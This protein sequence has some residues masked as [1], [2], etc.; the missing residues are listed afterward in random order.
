MTQRKLTFNHDKLSFLLLNIIG[1]D[2]IHDFGQPSCDK[3]RQVRK[4]IE[5]IRPLLLANSEEEET[6]DE[7]NNNKRKKR[8]EDENGTIDKKIKRGSITGAGIAR[9]ESKTVS[10]FHARNFGNFFQKVGNMK[11]LSDK[12]FV[13]RENNANVGSNFETPITSSIR[14]A[15]SIYSSLGTE[16]MDRNMVE[17]LESTKCNVMMILFHNFLNTKKIYGD[18]E[19]FVS[20]LSICETVFSNN[21]ELGLLPQHLHDYI[22]GLILLKVTENL[23]VTIVIDAR[24]NLWNTIQIR[25]VLLNNFGNENDKSNT[26]IINENIQLSNIIN[27]NFSTIIDDFFKSKF[28]FFDS[29]ADFMHGPIHTG[30][31]SI[32]SIPSIPSVRQIDDNKKSVERSRDL[33]DKKSVER[34]RDLPDKKTQQ[35]NPTLADSTKNPLRSG[36]KINNVSTVIINEND[37]KK[38]RK[39][40]SFKDGVFNDILTDSDI[41]G[42]IQSIRNA[43]YYYTMGSKGYLAENEQRDFSLDILKATFHKKSNPIP[44]SNDLLSVFIERQR[45]VVINLYCDMFQKLHV[46]TIKI[47]S[48]RTT[49]VYALA[50]QYKR[51]IKNIDDVIENSL[52]NIFKFDYQLRKK[53]DEKIRKDEIENNKN[54]LAASSGNLTN[55]NKETSYKFISFIAKSALY[56]TDCCDSSGNIIKKSGEGILNKEIE[57]IRA[58]AG[59]DGPHTG[60]YWKVGARALDIDTHLFSYIKSDTLLANKDIKSFNENNLK[61]NLTTQKQYVINNAANIGNSFQKRA[62][63]PYTSILDGM[64]QCSWKK[65]KSSKESLECGN[66]DFV[67]G[68]VPMSTFYNGTM[69]ILDEN[70]VKIG[71][72][73]KLS[74]CRIV[75]YEKVLMNSDTLVAHVVLRKTLDSIITYIDN[76]RN[77]S[78]YRYL[79]AET[80]IFEKL[81]QIGVD[82]LTTTNSTNSE[83]SSHPNSIFTILF[84]NILFKGVGDIFQE[85]NAI[86]KYGGYTG[87]NYKCGS[88]IFEYMNLRDNNK[89]Y[90]GDAP[91][92]FV[93]KDRVSVSRYLF[94]RGH[95]KDEEIN[96]ETS[97]G[98]IDGFDSAINMGAVYRK[99]RGG[100]LN[101]TTRKLH[102]KK[103]NRRNL[104]HKKHQKK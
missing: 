39:I 37:I 31:K 96:L 44:L 41:T 92:C 58:I 87:K 28:Y 101:K 47:N 86:A 45:D 9:N 33:P 60:D 97:G 90:N 104:T 94:I 103:Q 79:Y 30:G 98:Y 76:A 43:A 3:W 62:F 13:D 84:Q 22:V 82:D 7:Q 38:C 16:I 83:N 95:G 26:E 25:Y 78:K 99:Q 40:L 100:L 29:F 74:K 27:Y 65:A 34:S 81:F 102:T 93:A 42:T 66:M 63:C 2:P 14:N 91:R 53:Y 67:I 32:S 10:K 23:N 12:I 24:M 46:D 48:I 35:S 52:S 64:S 51:N 69:E 57:C 75:Q 49:L 36:I 6:E 56:L 5:E 1:H 55:C 17:Y 18:N 80:D 61:L 72:N 85:I 70:T 71:L 73:I 19:V 21:N 50:K 88:N 89:K 54:I 20:L 4:Q 8:D 59:R 15:N 68:D 77:S 11:K